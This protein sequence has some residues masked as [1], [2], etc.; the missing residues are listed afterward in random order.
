LTAI[1]FAE[2]TDFSR[3][4]P[5]GE[6]MNCIVPGEVLHGSYFFVGIGGIDGAIRVYT[7]AVKITQDFS[8][9][10]ACEYPEPQPNVYDALIKLIGEK[11]DK[12]QGEENAGKALVVGEDGNVVPKYIE[13]GGGS[14]GYNIGSGLKLDIST[15]TLSVDTAD[16]VEADNTKP[17]TSAAVHETVGNI[18]AILRII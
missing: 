16:E 6:D 7:D 14:C 9:F 13:G 3:A 2:D 11:I 18:E 12:N 8:C 5:L 1:F 10:S 4:V 15:N 17:I